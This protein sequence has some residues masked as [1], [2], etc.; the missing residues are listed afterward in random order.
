MVKYKI[1]KGDQV[2]VLTGKDKGKTGEITRMIPATGRAVVHGINLVKRHTRQT[3]TEEG[4]IKTKEAP[5]HISNLALIDQKSGKA[6][7]VGYKFDK[8]GTRI[9]F[10]KSSGEVI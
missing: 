8:D 1:R 10:A 6:T 2:I 5:I 7:R 4:G 3:Q 9:R